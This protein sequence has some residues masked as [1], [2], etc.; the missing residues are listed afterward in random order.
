MVFYFGM[1]KT[2]SLSMF[3]VPYWYWSLDTSVFTRYVEKYEPNIYRAKWKRKRLNEVKVNFDLLL[4]RIAVVCGSNMIEHRQIEIKKFLSYPWRIDLL[5]ICFHVLSTVSRSK[6]NGIIRRIKYGPFCSLLFLND[7][8]TSGNN[9]K[10]LMN[11]GNL[12]YNN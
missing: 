2:K 5:S 9:T 3:H 6:L 4:N 12:S 8:D 11:I 7:S 1:R 10:A